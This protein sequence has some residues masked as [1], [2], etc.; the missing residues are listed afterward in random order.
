MAD[1]IIFGA[2]I[3]FLNAAFW[4]LSPFIDRGRWEV[5]C[6]EEV[7]PGYVASTVDG[8][9]LFKSR[10]QMAAAQLRTFTRAAGHLQ[11]WYV[12][13]LKEDS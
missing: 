4:L 9:Y 8:R 11:P 2:V 7:A 13:D 5:R 12:R 6:D 1:V 10:A 3:A